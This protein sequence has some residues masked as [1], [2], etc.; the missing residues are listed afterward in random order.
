MRAVALALLVSA[1]PALADDAAALAL[2]DDPPAAPAAPAKPQDWRM[3]VESAMGQ[4]TARQ[5]GSVLGQQRLSLD[6]QWDSKFAPGWRG[7]LSDRLDVGWV[8]R[9]SDSTAVNSLREA[10]LS[11]QPAADNIVD[12]GR[13]NA[14]HGVATGYNP[15]DY[16]RSGANRSVVSVD[17]ASL[18]QNR[19]GTVMLRAQALWNGGSL[20]GTFSPRLA[21][22]PSD[23]SFSVDLGATNNRHRALFALSQ[24]IAEGIDPQW[25]LFA[26]EGRPPQLGLNLAALL[27]QSTVGHLE[28]SGGRSRS[29]LSQAVTGIDDGAF[30]SAP[31]LQLRHIARARSTC[32]RPRAMA[33]FRV[34]LAATAARAWRLWRRPPPTARR[35]CGRA[36]RRPGG[37]FERTDGP[38][39][40]SPRASRS[41]ADGSFAARS[42]SR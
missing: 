18:K 5:D 23:A 38:A 21:D 31:T 27:N 12:A 13:I 7:V 29:M 39:R 8:H 22:A 33:G 1:G 9:F 34:S 32:V 40:A 20:V 16:F 14:H 36:A 3:F 11:W 6:L 41:T 28:W 25:L 17:P 24:R 2:A 10:Y 35:P 15:T 19:L 30:R 4:T 37:S 42:R 26:E